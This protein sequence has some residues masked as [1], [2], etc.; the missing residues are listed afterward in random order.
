MLPKKKRA[1]RD[2]LGHAEILDGRG[3]N[4]TGKIFFRG[5]GADGEAM[6]GVVTVQPGRMR[7]SVESVSSFTSSTG[8][9]WSSSRTGKG[10]ELTKG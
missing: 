5:G 10:Y 8:K 1:G 2:D 7:R 6:S 3:E 9:Q 4:A